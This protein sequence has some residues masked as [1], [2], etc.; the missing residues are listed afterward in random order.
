MAKLSY[1]HF[2]FTTPAITTL[3]A[4]APAKAAGTTVAG[5]LGEFTHTAN[6]RLVY[7]GLTTRAFAVFVSLALL[8]DT[9]GNSAVTIHVYKNGSSVGSFPL[10]INNATDDMPMTW[11]GTTELATD[12]YLEIW[13]ETDTGDDLTVR[14]GSLLVSVLG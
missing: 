3:S 5:E 2:R 1:G 11:C 6:N 12:D 4:A 10:T 9:G 13:L 8:K 14:A 7:D